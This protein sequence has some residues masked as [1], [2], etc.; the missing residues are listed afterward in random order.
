[1]IAA[2]LMVVL[3]AGIPI[4][5]TRGEKPIHKIEEKMLVVLPFDNL[6][7][8]EDEY[9]SN[10]V[11]DEIT[12]RLSAL[13]GLGVISR[14]SALKYKNTNKTVKQIGKELDVDYILEGAVR[15]DRNSDGK[16]RVRVTP[17]LIRV[18]DDTHFWSESY[19][20]VL[21]DIFSVQSEIAE[22]V[23]RK[24]DLAILEPER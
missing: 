2:L 21:E 6:G 10:G 24:L 17:Q 9:F 12:S 18:E 19:D 20:R 7:S 22:Q 5:S 14:T 13:Q 1:M 3:L 23:A 15:W 16:G 8:P 11:T 4:L